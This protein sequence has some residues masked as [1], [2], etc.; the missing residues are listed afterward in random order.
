MDYRSNR[1]LP[2]EKS[3]LNDS[4]D[5]KMVKGYGNESSDN[6]DKASLSLR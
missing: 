1:R 5:L 3:H 2:I 4:G 6:N